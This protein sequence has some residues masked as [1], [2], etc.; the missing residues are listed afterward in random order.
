M[1]VGDAAAFEFQPPSV[2]TYSRGCGYLNCMTCLDACLRRWNSDSSA[3]D[4]RPVTS[5]LYGR[6][7]G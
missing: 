4:L 1:E 2:D 6:D 7:V 3:H 5:L